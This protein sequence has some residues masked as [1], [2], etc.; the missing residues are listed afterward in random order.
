MVSMA[1]A[2]CRE[3]H[4]GKLPTELLGVELAPATAIIVNARILSYRNEQAKTA[5]LA[6]STAPNTPNTPGKGPSVSPADKIRAKR[7]NM[8]A[9][10]NAAIRN[11]GFQ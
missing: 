1:D 11:Y 5:S 9:Q 7:M 8:M 2:L 10:R 4:L 6:D 3:Y